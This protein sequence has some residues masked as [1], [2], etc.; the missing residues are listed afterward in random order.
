MEI[1]SQSFQSSSAC[2]ACDSNSLELEKIQMVCRHWKSKG[3]CRYESQ[4][5]F[6]HPENKR[7]VSAKGPAQ[8]SD[9]P[10]LPIRPSRRRGGKNNKSIDASDSV[11]YFAN[12]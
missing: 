2:I 5:K 6:S 1:A 8:S 12:P 4:C 10:S 11:S 9:C 3:W 7:G